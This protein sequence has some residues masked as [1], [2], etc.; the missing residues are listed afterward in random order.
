MKI[1]QKQDFSARMARIQSGN[2]NTCGTI[3][4]GNETSAT[5]PRSIL[6]DRA[7]KSPS[8]AALMTKGLRS[9]VIQ[10]L[11]LGTCLAL[12]IRHVGL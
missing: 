3:H 7:I 5:M 4:V 10:V 9:A 8:R 2:A 1:E 12:Y 6:H 11:F